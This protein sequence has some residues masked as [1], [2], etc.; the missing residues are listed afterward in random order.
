MCCVFLWCVVKIIITDMKCALVFFTYKGD[1][2]LL[3]TALRAVPQLTRGG[4]E[5][6]CYVVDDAAAPLG[7]ESLPKWVHYMR[8]EFNRGG[9]LNGLECIAGMVGVY[10]AVMARGAYDWLIKADCDTYI[11]GLEWLR[12]VDPEVFS[13]VGTVHVNDHASGACYAMSARGVATVKHAL[14]EAKW[15]GAAER[16]HCED[17]VLY[18]ICKVIGNVLGRPARTGEPHP[19]RLCHDWEL[20]PRADFLELRQAAAVDFKRC[21]WNS[22]RELWQQDAAE[23]VARMEQYADYV[24]GLGR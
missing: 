23:A 1:A 4:N 13:F 12:G 9:N 5:V 20:L 17:K 15:R 11:N 24:E 14:E 10:D 7:R 19:L 3:A 22:K 2:Q 21:R 8:T 16:G 6:A 18:N